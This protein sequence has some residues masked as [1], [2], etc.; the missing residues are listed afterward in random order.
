MKWCDNGTSPSAL[1][2]ELLATSRDFATCSRK[3]KTTF[4]TD[5]LRSAMHLL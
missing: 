2:L 4:F 3:L 5:I 1:Q